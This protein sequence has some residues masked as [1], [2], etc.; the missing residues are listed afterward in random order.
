MDR[1]MTTK[2]IAG[3]VEFELPPVVCRRL[4]LAGAIRFCK[5]CDC[6][7]AC[8]DEEEQIEG[9]MYAIKC[10]AVRCNLDVGPGATRHGH[11]AEG[12][13]APHELAD[14]QDID[15][16]LLTGSYRALFQKKS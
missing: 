1:I 2:L 16:S 5:K 3:T 15:M 11:P 9:L 7:H 14:E 8:P 4:F 12:V 6:F 13:G 10:L